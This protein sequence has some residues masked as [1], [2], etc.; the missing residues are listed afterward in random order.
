MEQQGTFNHQVPLGL[1]KKKKKKN[2]KKKQKK[3][4]KQKQNKT[5]FC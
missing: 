2:E 5:I 4:T 3:K 1:F